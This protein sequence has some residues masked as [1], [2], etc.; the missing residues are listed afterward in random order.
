M[1]QAGGEEHGRGRCSLAH[2]SAWLRLSVGAGLAALAVCLTDTVPLLRGFPAMLILPA[3]ILCVWF[4]GYWGGVG[5]LLTGVPLMRIF[6]L[7]VRESFPNEHVPLEL[8]LLVI[9]LFSFAF[10]VALRSLARQRTALRTAELE[11]QLLQAEADRRQAEHRAQVSEQMRDR[12]AVLNLALSAN[13]M[14]LWIRDYL[15][16]A[17]YYSDEVCHIVGREPDSF[18][19]SFATWLKLIHPDDAE[20]VRH[21]MLA[22]L[23]TGCDYHREYRVLWPDGSV[24]WVE[25]RGK[26]QRDQHGRGARVVG[27]MAD[28][29]HRKLAEEAMMRAEKLAI[30]GRLAASVAHEINN[31]LEAVSNLLFLITLSQTAEQAHT[32]AATALEEL[33]R[34]G[35]IT[36]QMLSFHRQGGVP[37]PTELSTLASSVLAFFRAK[38]VKA[39]VSA[40]LRCQSEVEV[41]MRPGE[42]HQILGNLLTNSIEAMPGGGRLVLRLRRG[43][44]WCDPNR[45]GMRLSVVDTGSGI[46]RATL[47]RVTEPFFTTKADTGTGLGMWVV[48]Q[49]V[50]HHGG[51]L[52]LWSWQRPGASGT[53]VSIFLPVDGQPAAVGAPILRV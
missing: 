50:D 15:Q 18:D 40:E 51:D 47:G 39:G 27:V 3:I 16:R 43:R 8:R 17:N 49:L 31:P 37:Q 19:S 36:R 9:F 4:L 13:G 45:E 32:H 48:A 11:R 1:G 28:I 12:D 38:L 35:A 41:A 42:M 46:D 33:M 30:A 25:S 14:G 24:H 7:R 22:S 5:S 21:A 52:R 20:S 29:T 6:L 23:E 44:D 10:G 26:C 34:V 2:W 53:A